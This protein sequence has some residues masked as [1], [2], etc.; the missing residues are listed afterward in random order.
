MRPSETIIY[1]SANY[2]FSNS[3]SKKK[4][5]K[6][7][8]PYSHLDCI[9]IFTTPI[10]L[11]LLLRQTSC[12]LLLLLNR[13][14]SHGSRILSNTA[15]V[16]TRHLLQSLSELVTDYKY[17]I[18]LLR[19]FYSCY[20][21]TLSGTSIQKLFF[22]NNVLYQS[23]HDNCRIK[24]ANVGHTTATRAMCIFLTTGC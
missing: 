10:L 17:Y 3:Y 11:S 18:L 13:T 2:I 20:S 8:I 21:L 23:V 5:T 4:K 6:K 24:T 1:D 19:R 15:N 7:K 16:L 12:L 9:F 14:H 22:G